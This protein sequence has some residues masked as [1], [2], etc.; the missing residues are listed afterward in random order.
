MKG[1]PRVDNIAVTK[2]TM[3][4]G[5]NHMAIPLVC[6]GDEH[7]QKTDTHNTFNTGVPIDDDTYESVLQNLKAFS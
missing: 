1:H 5:E 4:Q 3:E 2:L 6:E 7:E